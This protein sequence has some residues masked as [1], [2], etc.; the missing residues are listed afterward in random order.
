MLILL[1]CYCF[2]AFLGAEAAH[3]SLCQFLS[4]GAKGSGT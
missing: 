4:G 3:G 1:I 2:T